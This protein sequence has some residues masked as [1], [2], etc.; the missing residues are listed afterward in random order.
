M[1]KDYDRWSL[2]PMLLK[3]HYVLHPLLKYEIMA[4]QLNDEDSCLDIFDMTIVTNE[5]TKEL[6]N[7]ELRML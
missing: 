6:V 1:V 7:R 2:F 5:I 4:N 3:C